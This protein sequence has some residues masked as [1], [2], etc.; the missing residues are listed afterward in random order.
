MI[1]SYFIPFVIKDYFLILLEEENL[2]L[3]I[4]FHV[5][6]YVCIVYIYFIFKFKELCSMCKHA[7]CMSGT[8]GTL[9]Y[10]LY[11]RKHT[12]NDIKELRKSYSFW[13]FSYLVLYLLIKGSLSQ[14]LKL[15][16]FENSAYY[17]AINNLLPFILFLSVAE[18]I[19]VKIFDRLLFKWAYEIKK[20][21]IIENNIE[22]IELVEIV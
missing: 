9:P 11:N 20:E 15:K 16:Q 1:I 3:E 6:I 14:N 7:I 5:L 13:V 10:S 21:D 4:L 2:F 17:N 8:L 22:E 12:L 19:L 18:F